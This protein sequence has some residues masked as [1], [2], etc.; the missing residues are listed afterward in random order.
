[1]HSSIADRSDRVNSALECVRRAMERGEALQQ[2]VGRER[3]VLSE[4]CEACERLLV[5]V[6]QDTAISR[7]HNKLVA[8]QR[9]RIAHL[10]KV[11]STDVH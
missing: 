8:K 7:E 10:R 1:M 3:V 9:G 4:K 11:S 2:R 6:A 5:Q